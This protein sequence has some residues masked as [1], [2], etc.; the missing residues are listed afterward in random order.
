M[1]K[2]I[3]EDDELAAISP[4]KTATETKKST[5]TTP[6]APVEEEVTE[7]VAEEEED[8]AKAQASSDDDD[9]DWGDERISSYSDGLDRLRPEK[10]SAVRFAI[11]HHSEFG[12]AKTMKKA[13]THY[14]EK[15]GTYQCHKTDDKPGECCRKLGEDSYLT[16]A[17]LVL[18][19]TN[20]NKLGRYAA[21]PDGKLPPIEYKIMYVQLSRTN[22]ND[23]GALPEDG[24]KVPDIDIIMSHKS[25]TGKGGYKFTLGQSQARWKK[26][27]ALVKEVKAAVEKFTDGRKLAGK[28]GK[29]ISPIEMKL[30]LASLAAPAVDD[31]NMDDIEGI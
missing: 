26:N 15:K 6:S 31:A 10:G 20:A 29:K 17:Q 21:G 9:A 24:G 7:E 2:F 22:Y 11:L 5:P 27:A 1:A 23:I 3:E 30:L 19:Y 12:G 8:G 4:T 16:L 28:L 13:N 14:I 25:N 18:C